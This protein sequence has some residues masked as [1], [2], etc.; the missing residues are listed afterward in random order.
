MLFRL[1]ARFTGDDAVFRALEAA[2]RRLAAGVADAVLVLAVDATGAGAVVLARADGDAARRVY[3]TIDALALG[4]A[5]DVPALC[6][7]ALAAA[8]VTPEQVGYLEVSGLVPEDAVEIAGVLDAYRTPSADLTCALGSAGAV[9]GM[10]RLVKTALCLYRRYLPAMPGW[11]G[12]RSPEQWRGSPF[13]VPAA[14]Y[15]WF[16][17]PGTPR[18]VAALS[19]RGRD[20]TYAHAVLTEPAQRAP[21]RK[22]RTALVAKT[23]RLFPLV[24]A[25]RDALHGRLAALQRDVA[26]GTPLPDLAH[27]A[28]AAAQRATNAPYLL[29]ITGH[30]RETVLREVRFAIKGLDKAFDS[31][32]P[33]SSPLG[34]YFT[35]APLGREGAVAFVY[36]G[37]FNSYPGMGRDLFQLFPF[38]HERFAAVTANASRT[39]ATRL[40]YPRRLVPPTAEEVKAQQAR[41]LG[42][43]IAMIE[44]GAGFAILYTLMMQEVFG[45]RPQAALGYSLGE[46]SMLWAMGVWRN[47]DAG[48]DAWHDSPLFKTRLFGRMDAVREAWGLRGEA[49]DDLWAVYILKAPP[50]RVRAALEG[51]PR[52]Y[53][54]IV[55]TPR[56]VVI[57]GDPAG[58][59]RVIAALDC[60]ALQVP[61]NA[62]IHNAAM[63][64]EYAAFVDLYTLPVHPAPG[65]DFYSASGYAPLVLESQALAHAIAD[66]SCKPIDFDRL[67]RTVYAGG[68]RLFVEL[69]PLGTCS[70][71]IRRILA[72]KPHAVVPVNRSGAGDLESILAVLAMLLSHRVPV[73]VAALYPPAKPV[74]VQTAAA[75]AIAMTWQDQYYDN[76]R[77]HVA[78]VA[79]GHAA[80]LQARRTALRQTADLIGLQMDVAR[81]V[82]FATESSP[83][84]GE[85]SAGG[86]I[87]GGRPN[88]FGIPASASQGEAL[89]GGVGDGPNEFG[90]PK[91]VMFDE[92]HVEAFA[93]GD[94][95]DCFGPMY[96]AYRGRRVPRIPRGALKLISRVVTID[97]PRGEVQAGASLVSE[98]DVPA[99]AWFYRES[100]AAG[101]S[102]LGPPHAGGEGDLPYAVLMEIAL[103]PCGFLSAYAGSMFPYP[104]TDFYFRNLDG[105][106]TLL[107]DFDARGR[108]IT[109]RVQLL[110]STAVRGIIIQKY[111]FALACEGEVF[112]RGTSSFGYFTPEALANQVGLD[113]AQVQPPWIE[114]AGGGIVVNVAGPP[115]GRLRFLDAVRVVAEGGR[116]GRGYVYATLP[117]DPEDWFFACHFLDDPVMPGS[118]G[119]EA[120]RQAML[121]YARHRIGEAHR[122]LRPAHVPRHQTRWK[123]RGQIPPERDT[124]QLE[125][126]LTDFAVDADGGVSVIGDGSLWRQ[127]LRIYEVT[128]LALRVV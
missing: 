11:R 32:T 104:E 7:Q 21:E 116:H 43:P 85:M 68:A 54:T 76:L 124:V 128:G 86:G 108:T 111:S 8:G 81:R 60:H 100:R 23:F 14:A 96:A 61:F 55:N 92:G 71:W 115:S 9:S 37:A 13:Y 41:L 40:L 1:D 98:V 97:G 44:S 10:A 79:E 39:L 83:G 66:M 122:G 65:V 49:R 22:V 113:G 119:I 127:G 30:D 62:V 36:P 125:V 95:A 112:Y 89:A 120:M 121:V 6:R 16:R 56:E 51:E 87:P 35:P 118:L 19:H 77:R 24:G 72:G 2:R 52:V 80:F 64:S 53:L 59:R 26:G 47:G 28:F 45:V 74:M 17:E 91:R 63:R 103:Q 20:G 93:A 117:V 102:P 88:K 75:P 50:A 25:S 107:R 48:S 84:G 70:R 99:D 33:W 18:R 123:Y 15:T 31:G 58:C 34:S 114:E 109:N 82:L 42:D 4:R 38:L 12:P 105:E 90:R 67:V 69:G 78:R 110:S 5:E 3:A 101:M 46:I 106:G 73:D 94:L 57:A 126:H 29:A 27:R